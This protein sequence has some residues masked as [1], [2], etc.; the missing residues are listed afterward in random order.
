[1]VAAPVNVAYAHPQFGMQFTGGSMSVASEW[2][3]LR[4]AGA[5]A[6]RCS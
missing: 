4:R 6:A 3:R 2:D 5:T 1:V